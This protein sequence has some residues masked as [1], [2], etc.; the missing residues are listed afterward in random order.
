MSRNFCSS[1]RADHQDAARRARRARGQWVLAHV[2]RDVSTAHA[3]THHVVGPRPLA[4]YTP[5]GAFEAYAYRHADGGALW[6]RYVEGGE[7]V[8][9][10]PATMTVRVRHDGDGPGYEGVGILTVT[11]PARCPQCGGPRGTDTIRRHVFRADGETHSVDVWSNPCGHVDL[12]D[13]VVRESQRVPD[14]PAPA[15]PAVPAG[16]V[17][18]TVRLITEAADAREI[19]HAKSA[20]HLLA[21]H[22]HQA[23]A[24][25]ILAEVRARHGHMSARQ[26]AVLLAERA[27]GGDG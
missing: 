13:E 4:A 16:D 9:A 18:E 14:R 8:P 10:L 7:P 2:Y 3:M 23:E 20:A 19:V 17:P 24:D 26:A 15:P 6:V 21:R 25:L 27:R 22:G 5:R 11:V 12:Y 1:P